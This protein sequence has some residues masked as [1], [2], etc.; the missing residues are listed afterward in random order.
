VTRSTRRSSTGSCE[1][2]PDVGA[3][4]HPDPAL[5]T[6]WAFERARQATSR[7]EIVALIAQ[8]G[9]PW[10]A[11]PS[12]W[13]S[14][15]EVWLALLPHLPLTAL[16]RNLAR[17][18]ANRALHSAGRLRAHGGERLVKIS[19]RCAGRASTRSPCWLR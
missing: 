11:I 8:H 5:R 17:M 9:L 2:W 12:T 16:L 13:L 19:G 15:A 6:L 14:E 4:P 7:D 18:T 1:G 3:E 10:E